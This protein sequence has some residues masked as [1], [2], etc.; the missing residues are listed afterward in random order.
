MNTQNVNVKTATK[1]HSERWVKT[2][3]RV[4]DKARYNVAC[5]EE[6]SAHYGERFTRLDACEFFIRGVLS[7]CFQKS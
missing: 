1:N 4:I 2:I 5:A 7:A 6:A 3:A